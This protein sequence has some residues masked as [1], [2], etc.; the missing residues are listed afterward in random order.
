MLLHRFGLCHYLQSRFVATALGSLHSALSLL[1]ASLIFATMANTPSRAEPDLDEI[2][3]QAPKNGGPRR[4]EV[5]GNT[6][7]IYRT[8]S[9]D[10]AKVGVLAKGDILSNSGC[11]KEKGQIWCEVRSIRNGAR[12]HARAVQL[13]PARG[14]DGTVPMGVD[15]S[16]RRA[17]KGDFD[18]TR[19][20]PCAQEQGQALGRCRAAAAHGGGGDATVIVTFPNGFARHLYFVH[21][22]FVRANATMSGVGTDIDWRLEKQRHILRVDDQRFELPNILVFGN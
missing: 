12:G 9:A 4:W 14:P 2:M 1:C 13:A 3:L 20:I 22:E 15:R 7:T 18:A 21:G 5:V 10:A 19:D 17:L 6:L 11:S 16:K 8:P